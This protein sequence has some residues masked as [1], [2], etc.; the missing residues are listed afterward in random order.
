MHT[1]VYPTH[2]TDEHHIYRNARVTIDDTG[3][4]T[5]VNDP[6]DVVLETYPPGNW[7]DVRASTVDLEPEGG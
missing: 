6:D 5:V 2:D 1:I 4:L 3:T 7:V